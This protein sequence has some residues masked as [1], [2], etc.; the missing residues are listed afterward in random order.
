MTVAPLSSQEQSKDAWQV[1]PGYDQLSH[2]VIGGNYVAVSSLC[3]RQL[4]YTYTPCE[5]LQRPDDLLKPR[6]FMF[7]KTQKGRPLRPPRQPDSRVSLQ[8]G[9]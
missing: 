4:A 5:L 1:N 7:S 8:N 2:L 6:F 3:L 9:R